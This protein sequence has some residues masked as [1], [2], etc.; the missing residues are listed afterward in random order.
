MRAWIQTYGIL[1][2]VLGIHNY[3]HSAELPF[4]LVPA[5]L[6]QHTST[7][8][9]APARLETHRS[10][11]STGSATSAGSSGEILLQEQTSGN[12]GTPS[13]STSTPGHTPPAFKESEIMNPDGGVYGKKFGEKRKDEKNTV[14]VRTLSDD[15]YSARDE[16]LKRFEEQNIGPAQLQQLKHEE[17]EREAFERKKD[18]VLVRIAASTKRQSPTKKEEI[19]REKE[20]SQHSLTIYMEKRKS[21]IEQIAETDPITA[22][23]IMHKPK[24]RDTGDDFFNISP[25]E[26]PGSSQTPS[27][28]SSTFS[29]VTP[30]PATRSP[31]LPPIKKS[32]V[33][34]PMS[35]SHGPALPPL[36]P[37]NPSPLRG[38]LWTQS[39][40]R[41]AHDKEKDR[42]PALVSATQLLTRQSPKKAAR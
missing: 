13:V 34:A 4:H 37:L 32:P 11:T 24:P 9:L 3:L 2:I 33:A 21:L 5:P 26:S 29:S 15:L 10:F 36:P 7:D 12:S 19:E 39:Q 20:K 18:A 23:L 35:P 40:Y 31:A 16:Q 27:S 1:C 38:P 8:D 14:K 22:A 6:Q 30:S 41:E 17:Q 25:S 28:T 42:L